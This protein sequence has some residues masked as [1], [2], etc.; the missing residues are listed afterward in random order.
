MTA[1]AQLLQKLSQGF[2]LTHDDVFSREHSVGGIGASLPKTDG[3]QPRAGLT[4]PSFYE[5]RR[6]CVNTRLKNKTPPSTRNPFTT[7]T[8]WAQR[9]TG[10]IPTAT[11]T[12]SAAVT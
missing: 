9:V 8:T 3:S 6:L 7:K 4:V 2:S 10:F 5:N 1:Q 12:F 11:Y